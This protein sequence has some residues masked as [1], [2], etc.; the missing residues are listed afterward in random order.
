MCKVDR[1]CGISSRQSDL[2]VDLCQYN[3]CFVVL[4]ANLFSPKFH[5]LITEKC[6]DGKTD[7][8][9]PKCLVLIPF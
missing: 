6:L 9:R 2:L 5:M 1:L 8:K 4:L 3:L 7:V